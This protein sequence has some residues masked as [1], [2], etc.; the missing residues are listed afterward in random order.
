MG[1]Y[2]L[3]GPAEPLDS[4]RL[5]GRADVE[6]VGGGV[7]GCACAL[8]LAQAGLAVRVHETRE[9][10]SGASGRN[11]GF[12]LRGGAMGYDH[13]RQSLGRPRARELWRFTEDALER[14]AGLA[15]TAFRRTGSVRLA[16]DREERG[17]LRADYRALAEDG[18]VVE[19]LDEVETPGGVRFPGAIVHPEDGALH[20]AAWVRRL[21]RL[22]ADAGVEI[23]EQSRVEALDQ[24]EADQVVLATDGYTRGLVPELEAAIRPTRG[25]VLVTA[26]LQSPVFTRP[27]YAR[28]GYDY[29]Q[30]TPDRRLVIGG[31]RDASLDTEWTSEE[32][33]TERIQR[34]IE[35]LA[36]TLVGSLPP[37]THRWCGIFGSTAD[38]LPLVGEL[39][40][41]PGTWVAAGYSGHGNVLGLAC[42]EAVADAILGRPADPV[43]T[44]FDPARTES[45]LSE[46]EPRHVA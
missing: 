21:A 18:F 36:R 26:P 16:W 1:S 3:E 23:R 41:R 13:A 2:W 37:V 12:A 29:W 4:T 19:W 45:G 42:G 43:V 11:G 7:T 25:Q 28:H 40:G 14:L 38:L 35:E 32:E 46:L 5:R 22:A 44:V 15:G 31:Q 9:V 27:H 10:A 33:P 30:Q 39:P 24:L 34:R 8:A 17:D 20:P 6:I